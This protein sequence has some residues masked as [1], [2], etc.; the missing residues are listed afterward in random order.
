MTRARCDTTPRPGGLLAARALESLRA[1]RR[2]VS[3]ATNVAGLAPGTVF[4][5]SEHPHAFAR[6]RRAAARRRAVDARLDRRAVVHRRSRRLRGSSV[7]AVAEDPEAGRERG[8]E[9]DRGQSARRGDPHRR[10]S[11]RVRVR[12]P[13][14]RSGRVGDT[15]SCWIRVSQG[16]AGAGYGSLMLPRVGQ[17]VLVG[18]LDGD[19]PAGRRQSRLPA[20]SPHP[21]RSPSTRRGARGGAHHRLA[22]PGATDPLRGSCW[23]RAVARPRAA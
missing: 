12:F 13:W 23:R 15:S 18:F 3:F 5:I 14:D 21:T 10:D 6:A 11:G 19:R 22:A 16:W 4:A 17:E 1:D 2:R 7:P 8:S 9:R 20:L